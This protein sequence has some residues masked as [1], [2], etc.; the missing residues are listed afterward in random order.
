MTQDSSVIRRC[1]HWARLVPRAHTWQKPAV[2]EQDPDEGLRPKHRKQRPPPPQF[3][4]TFPR[5]R[6]QRS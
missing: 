2:S 5:K 3:Q 6:W 4:S 1:N